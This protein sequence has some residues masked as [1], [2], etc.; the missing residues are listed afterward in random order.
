MAKQR[1]TPIKFRARGLVCDAGID[2]ARLGFLHNIARI[3][4]C[5]L[6]PGNLSLD[7]VIPHQRKGAGTNQ[8]RDDRDAY[9]FA[10]SDPNCLR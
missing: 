4:L 2:G 8:Y 7:I 6:W 1:A 3:D 10:P 9:F 5:D